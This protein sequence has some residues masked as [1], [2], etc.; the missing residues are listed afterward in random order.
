MHVP[1]GDSHDAV[2]AHRSK[3]LSEQG[4]STVIV[5]R[6]KTALSEHG[7]RTAIV[8]ITRLV[9]LIAVRVIAVARRCLGRASIGPL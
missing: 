5:A 6:V 4:A 3:A 1:N 7:A 8:I 9:R 2:V